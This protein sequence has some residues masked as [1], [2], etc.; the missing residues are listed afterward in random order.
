[1]RKV[2]QQ[3]IDAITNGREFRQ[4]NTVV[5]EEWGRAQQPCE[6]DSR[7]WVVYLHGNEIARWWPE[8]EVLWVSDAGWRTPTTKSRLNALLGRFFP[9]WHISQRGGAWWLMTPTH[10]P[11]VWHGRDRFQRGGP[12]ID[13][14]S[15]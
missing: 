7:C 9:G 15:T 10:I 3:M 5:R 6:L 11:M 4:G 12:V 14:G 1:M 2:E 13:E 8:N